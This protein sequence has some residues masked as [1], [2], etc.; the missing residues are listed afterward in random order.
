MPAVINITQREFRNQLYDS[1]AGGYPGVSSGNDVT[2]LTGSVMERV[3]LEM[4]IQVYWYSKSDTFNTYSITYSNPTLTITSQSGSFVDEGLSIGDECDFFSGPVYHDEGTITNISPDGR[5]LTVNTA[6]YTGPNEAAASSYV[7]IGKSEL[8][9]IQWLW[10][11]MENNDPFNYTSV[12]DQSDQA[13]YFSPVGDGGPRSTDY[14]DGNV[15]NGLGPNNIARWQIGDIKSK[16]V[17]DLPLTIG[18][19]NY[20]TKS[21]NDYIQEFQVE[22]NFVILPWDDNTISDLLTGTNSLKYAVRAIFRNSLNNPNQSKITT[23][24]IQ[25]GSVAWFEENA[26][27]FNTNYQLSNIGLVV[28]SSSSSEIIKNKVTSVTIDVVSPTG[29]FA[30]D[31]RFS[32]YFSQTPSYNQ[33]TTAIKTIE[34]LW[35]YDS[36]TDEVGGSET[37]STI[38][39]NVA[40]TRPDAYN[41]QITFD[42]EFTSAQQDVIE[43]SAV[44]TVAV[45]VGDT[46]LAN[47]ASDRVTFRELFTIDVDYDNLTR[48]K[49]LTFMRYDNDDF[50]E[51]VSDPC[52][53]PENELV[54]YIHDD[55][56]VNGLDQVDATLVG[57]RYVVDAGDTN[58]VFG[59]AGGRFY[60]NIDDLP[61]PLTLSS[62]ASEQVI[63]DDSVVVPVD[64]TIINTLWG[65]VSGLDEGRLNNIGVWT[66][67]DPALEWIGFSRCVS[68]PTTRTYCIGIAADNRCK[69]YLDGVLIFEVTEDVTNAFNYWHIFEF[70]LT[71]GDH[72]IQ[73][74]G[75]NTGSTASFGCEI[76]Q[77]NL[78][79]LQAITTE[80]ALEALTIFSTGDLIGEFFDTGN[81]AGWTCPSGYTLSYCGGDGVTP[82]CVIPTVKAKGILNEVQVEI[83]AYNSTEETEFE[84]DKFSV[85][86]EGEPIVNGE[87]EVDLTEL[88]NYNLDDDANRKKVTIKKDNLGSDLGPGYTVK[89]AFRLR[90]EDFIALI[91]VSDDFFDASLENNG[92]NQQ[93]YRYDLGD[94]V[95]EPRINLIW[96]DENG[97]AYVDQHYGD[98]NMLNYDDSDVFTFTGIKSYSPSDVDLGGYMLTDGQ[99]TTVEFEYEYTGVGSLSPSNIIGELNFSDLGINTDFR[100]STEY[101]YLGPWQNTPTVTVNGSTILIE[102]DF[103]ANGLNFVGERQ[104]SSYMIIKIVA[105]AISF[106]GTDE[107]INGDA[108]LVPLLDSTTG[109]VSIWINPVDAS[110]ASDQT[111]I[112]WGDT[113]ANEVMYITLKT[114]GKI[115][116]GC[117]VGGTSQ[118]VFDTDSTTALTDATWTQIT[119]VQNGTTPVLYLD[120]VSEAITYSVSTDQT[121]W[122][123]SLTGADNY[124][125]ACLNY[126]SGGNTQFL[127]A[128]LDDLG[129]WK[130]DLG[131]AEALEIYGAGTPIDLATDTGN[132]TS[133]D[134]LIQYCKMGDSGTFSTNWY[135]PESKSGLDNFQSV[136]FDGIDEYA[137]VDAVLTPLSTT[138]AGTWSIWVKP[139]QINMTNRLFCFGDTNANE[140]IFLGITSVNTIRA[141]CRDGGVTAW[142]LRTDA[143]AV[144]LE[145]WAHIML[146]QDGT[147]PVIYVNGV[148]VAQTFSSSADKTKWFNDCTGLDNGRVGAS[149]FSTVI[150]GYMDGR[151]DEVGFWKS[152]LTAA[153]CLAVYADGSPKD[154]SSD[155]GNYASSADL[156]TWLKMGDGDTHPTLTDSV[157]TYDGTL[158]NTEASDIEYSAP[159]LLETVNMEEADRVVRT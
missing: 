35:L 129:V 42:L 126:N 139:A 52:E 6:T 121:I 26:N 76:Y 12:I 122:L 41:L 135:L 61:F 151:L 60:D 19:V 154:I 109:T 33:Q 71:A 100:S 158:I 50:T 58:T 123:D 10:N 73:M 8:K 81:S 148:A 105:Y 155:Y 21:G 20:S 124:R 84:L 108:A 82:V 134:D 142:D 44:G 146:V 40:S 140:F 111:I 88:R 118:W 2:F 57:T 70:T 128:S 80:S 9:G 85:N 23:D 131:A 62:A 56:G 36:F 91:G 29:L 69:F 92:W 130:S 32:V 48:T 94:W 115:E 75:Y 14:V 86:I 87:R 17:Q 152:G 103:D 77:E 93:W 120:G 7:I 72:T 54:A 99:L 119:L 51:L 18:I 98:V 110:P 102:A 55:F 137:D 11:L 106:G 53:F 27:G 156:V 64:N 101:G 132:Y 136:L 114:T 45:Q 68:V 39:K 107:Y 46:S 59:D 13:Y 37:Q 116:V 4:L 138:T 15:L 144:S 90:W 157:G 95:I 1:V 74:E 28:D 63:D 67:S 150:S 22:H 96:E 143:A 149:E 38:I 30:S 104:F 49:D 153:E 97:I 112:S 34:E 133:S 89:G 141:I 47:D 24:D 117:I 3:T 83:V 125:I 5:T 16:F 78:T 159:M 43:S 25:L 145:E 31:Q 127:I 113:D 65:Y 66:P 147:S 79:D